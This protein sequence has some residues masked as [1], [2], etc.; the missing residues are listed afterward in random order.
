MD[1]RFHLHIEACHKHY[2]DVFRVSPNELSFSGAQAWTDIYTPNDKGVARISKS[3]YY[4]IFGVGFEGQG[5][6]SER[7]AVRGHRLRRIF[8]PVFSMKALRQQE[9]VIQASTDLLVEKLGKLGNDHGGVDITKWFEYCTHDIAGELV[10][11]K[12]LDCVRNG[13]TSYSWTKACA[14]VF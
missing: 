4:D 6:A 5:F 10:F 13:I 3:D 11:G 9:A 12:S 8:D 2:G 1:G 14:N 7:D